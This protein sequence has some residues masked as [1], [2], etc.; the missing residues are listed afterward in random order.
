M[1]ADPAEVQKVLKALADDP[2]LLRSIMEAT[3]AS[4]KRQL[5]QGAG[6]GTLSISD[7]KDE[8]DKIIGPRGTGATAA[9]VSGTL[10]ADAPAH[11]AAVA[12][13]AAAAAAPP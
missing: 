11:M 1:P 8:L 13:A 2:N 10:S 6:L 5:L 4:A 12:A 7:V 9:G 3:S